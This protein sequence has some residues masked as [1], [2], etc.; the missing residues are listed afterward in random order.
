M[1]ESPSRLNQRRH[2]EPAAHPSASAHEDQ[3]SL[4]EQVVSRHL[5]SSRPERVEP[6]SA[7]RQPTPK[8]MGAAL[9]AQSLGPFAGMGSSSDILIGS[10]SPAPL[11]VSLPDAHSGRGEEDVGTCAGAAADTA[12]G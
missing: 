2:S 7:A 8:T 4:D 10:S 5:V 11:T 3:K 1:S 9:T 12:G 6:Y